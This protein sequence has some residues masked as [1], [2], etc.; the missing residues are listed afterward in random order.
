MLKVSEREV[1]M[2]WLWASCV[3]VFTPA[4]L[5]IQF[6]SHALGVFCLFYF[7][8]RAFWQLRVHA[9]CEESLSRKHQ[10]FGNRIICS[11]LVLGSKEPD[12]TPLDTEE[13]WPGFHCVAFW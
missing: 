13:M 4:S 12:R 6:A 7:L 11:P 9:Y 1:H 3:G 8:S 10:T 5:Q 2:E